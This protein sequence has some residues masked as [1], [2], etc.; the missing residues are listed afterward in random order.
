LEIGHQTPA[1]ILRLPSGGIARQ[2][3]LGLPE[4][5]RLRVGGRDPIIG[6]GNRRERIELLPLGD[7]DVVIGDEVVRR[8]R[9][10]DLEEPDA[11]HLYHLRGR[12]AP[13]DSAPF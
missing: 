3:F 4:A 9:L 13:T 6:V 2:G 11:A 12:A 1:A 5:Q 10:T 8:I 7:K